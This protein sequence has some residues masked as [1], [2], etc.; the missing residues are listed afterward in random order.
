MQKRVIPLLLKRADVLA[1]SKSGTGKTAAFTLP[2]LNKLHKERS[3]NN[4]VLRGLILVPTRE[5]VDQVSRVLATYGKYLKVR[6]TKIKGGASKKE[7]ID[8]LDSG[9]DIIVATPGRL[10]DL[11]ESEQINLE[12]INYV[13][14]DEADTMLEMGF[15][16]DIHFIFEHCS[17]H[18]QISM[19]SATISQNVKKLAKKFLQNPSV[20]EVSDRR[21]NV[22]LIHHKAYKVDVKS[23]VALVA[24][25]I[26]ESHGAQIL[27]FVS[28]KENSDTL[29]KILKKSGINVA[30]VHGDIS[31]DERAKSIKNFISK[32]VQV[33]I[34]SDIA[35]RGIDIKELPMVINFELPKEVDDFTHRVGR[36]GRAGNKGVVLTILT[37]HEYNEFSNIERKLKINAKRE[38]HP[39]FPLKDRQPRQKMMKKKSL[40]EKKGYIKKRDDEK[41]KHDKSGAKSKKTTKR[42]VKKIFGKKKK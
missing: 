30:L 29:F 24:T 9:I 19:F 39:D 5:L 34:A 26:K 40:R 28:T 23:K 37:V 16:K 14:L 10:K 20:V 7:Q 33:L 41:D 27:I 32:K 8:K 22:N 21:D 18:K 12:S 1:G 17:P 13:V 38:I 6:H 25:V 36:T 2:L 35:A 4:P 3:E 15:I 42:D 31:Y 11:V